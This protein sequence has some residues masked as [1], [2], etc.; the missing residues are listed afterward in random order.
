MKPNPRSWAAAAVIAAF[1][2]YREARQWGAAAAHQAR[3]W[4]PRIRSVAA[5]AAGLA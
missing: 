4:P 1:P 3:P 5:V 2:L